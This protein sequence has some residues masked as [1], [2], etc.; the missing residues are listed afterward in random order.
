MGVVLRKGSAVFGTVTPTLE[1]AVVEG[2]KGDDPP[3]VAAADKAADKGRDQGYDAR[4]RSK[5]D[6]LVEKTR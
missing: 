3:A 6:D 5:M 1:K 2:V 4:A